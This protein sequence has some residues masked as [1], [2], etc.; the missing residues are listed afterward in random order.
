MG[1]KPVI[2]GVHFNKYG[3]QVAVVFSSPAVFVKI[4]VFQFVFRIQLGETD[5]E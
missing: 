4:V 5:A 3:N 2:Q 1:E